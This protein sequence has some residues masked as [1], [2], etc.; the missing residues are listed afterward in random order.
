MQ[1]QCSF[2]INISELRFEGPEKMIQLNIK[3]L[4]LYLKL[5]FSN[6][7][8]T[9]NYTAILQKST[10]FD[11]KKGFF[12]FGRRSITTRKSKRNRK[13]DDKEIFR[14]KQENEMNNESTCNQIRWRRKSLM[15]LKE[16]KHSFSIVSNSLLSSIVSKTTILSL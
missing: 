15:L 2:K 8:N 9:N 14:V 6:L 12:F 16:R 10:S 3:S 4:K 5:Q 7:I 1:D 11:D 13:Q